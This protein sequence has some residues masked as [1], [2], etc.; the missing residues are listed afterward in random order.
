MNDSL[1]FSTS[2]V[3]KGLEN[4]IEAIKNVERIYNMPEKVFEEWK[5]ESLLKSLKYTSQNSAFY[6]K[7]LEAFSG[8]ESFDLHEFSKI[9]FTL[10]SEIKENYPFGMLAASMDDIVRYGES[11]GTSDKPIAS[12]YTLGEWIEN[13]AT[14]ALFLNEVLTKQDIVA[15]AVPYE[16]AFVAQD[17]DRSLEM[18]NCTIISIGALTR[19]CPPERMIQLFK[20]IKVTTLICSVTRAIY[21]S[22]VAIEMGFDPSK[23]FS[24]NKVM[25]VGEG[26]S[27]AK[28]ALVRKLWNAET[29]SMYGM[30]ETNTLGM[31]CKEHNQHLVETKAHFEVIDSVTYEPLGYDTFGELIVTSLNTKGIPLIRYRTGDLVKIKSEKC[32]CGL[33]FK[34]FE[35]SGRLDDHII[36]KNKK[37]PILQLEQIIIGLGDTNYYTLEV[38]EDSLKI[39]LCNSAEV[40]KKVNQQ[41]INKFKE[42]YNLSVTVFPV[43]NAKVKDIIRNSLKPC[44][45]SVLVNG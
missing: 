41:I 29:Y 1:K 22:D 27:K 7:K 12:Y 36:I 19:I 6:K 8:F 16:L 18:L 20:D 3:Q 14:V 21:L 24:I 23:D 9:P 13:N 43:E 2:N 17:I 40:F 4:R 30:T 37:Y 35:H 42:T 39:G 38:V 28:E 25:C 33:T 15:V 10:R 31:F 34:T 45:K 44:I 32:S 26:M 5:T 11:T